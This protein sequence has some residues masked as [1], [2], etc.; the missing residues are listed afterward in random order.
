MKPVQS[1]ISDIS[2]DY[3]DTNVK[4]NKCF[5]CLKSKVFV[6]W[7]ILSHWQCSVSVKNLKINSV[8][9]C[10]ILSHLQI[11]FCFC[12]ILNCPSWIK[13]VPLSYIINRNF[14]ITQNRDQWFSDMSCV[15]TRKSNCNVE[16][17]CLAALF[18]SSHWTFGL[19]RR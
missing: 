3:N 8:L 18:P 11:A 5:F 19:G 14:I 16:W 6:I 2:F 4:R 17:V 7:E 15:I 12:E 13:I 9:F 1:E 10:E